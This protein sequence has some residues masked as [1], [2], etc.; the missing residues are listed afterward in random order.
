MTERYLHAE[1]TAFP[2]AAE[3]VERRIFGTPSE[4]GSEKG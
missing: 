3:F 1:K 4:D 2:D